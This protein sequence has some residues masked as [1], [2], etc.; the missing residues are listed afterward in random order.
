MNASKHPGA[1]PADGPLEV[2]QPDYNARQ[3]WS[4]VTILLAAAIFAQAIFAGLMLSGIEWAYTAHKVNATVLAA[5]T[6][7][8]GLSSL[9]V[10]RRTTHGLRLGF[11]LL[12]LA[13]VVF[14][15][16][17]IGKFSAEGANLMWAH[18]PLG[19][20]LVGFAMQAVAAARKLGG[21]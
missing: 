6:L 9:F 7:I 1:V 12:S 20:A 16:T 14:L 19:V 21:A 18:I 2:N 11:T 3:I 5:S 4:V 8:A 10:L 13:V 15:Q 17:A